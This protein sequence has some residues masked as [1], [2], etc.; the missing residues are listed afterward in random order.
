MAP[1]L[2]KPVRWLLK[3]LR[4]DVAASQAKKLDRIAASGD[5]VMRVQFVKLNAKWFREFMAFEP[6]DALRSGAVPILAI[7]GAKDMQ[8]DPADVDAMGDA[9]TT[10]FSGKVIDDLTHLLRS[11]PGPATL[12]TYKKQARRPVDQRVLDL[13]V[14]W[15]AA[16]VDKGADNDAV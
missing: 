2:P 16:H 13:V 6:I 4:Q 10:P 15:I 8:V 11:E 7:T 12:R 14:D 3:L 5:D 1:T 9:A